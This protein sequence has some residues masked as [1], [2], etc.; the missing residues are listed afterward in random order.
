MKKNRHRREA[1]RH[2]SSRS[3]E[4]PSEHDAKKSSWKSYSR[5]ILEFVGVVIVAWLLYQGLGYALQTDMPMVSVVSGSM[6]PTL[7]VGDLLIIS[8]ASYAPGDIAVYMRGN[9]QIVHRIIDVTAD[10]KYIF[11]GDNNPGPD[12]APVARSQLIGK[13]RFAIPLLGYPR[14]ALYAAGI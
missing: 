1:A 6:E 13:V 3:R 4:K 12:P 9:V 7:H 11:R 5:D 2:D 10:G 8:N 14:L